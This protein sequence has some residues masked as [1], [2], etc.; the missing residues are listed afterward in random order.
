MTVKDEQTNQPRVV[1]AADQVELTGADLIA[2]GQ[3]GQ[4]GKWVDRAADIL[5]PVIA[6]VVLCTIW[7]LLSRADPGWFPRAILP[8]PSE[9]AP[10]LVETLGSSLM[11]E[12]LAVTLEEVVIAFGI[13]LVGGFLLG[14]AIA[15]SRTFNR[16]VYP[17]VIAF[18]S[19]P[20]SAFAP[21]FIAWFGF[22]I[23]SKIALAVTISFF[24]VLATTITGLNLYKENEMLL[25]RS[26]RATRIQTFFRLR[27]PNA[28]PTIF[29]GVK[30]S[31]TFAVVGVVFGEM[32]GANEGIGL[33]IRS[34]AA[35]LRM[36][37]MFSYLVILAVIGVLIVLLAEIA[38]RKITFWNR[39]EGAE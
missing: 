29:A 9:I 28:M 2:A 25:M 16:A 24:P 6:F 32:I 34:S 19:V 26:L 1:P 15:L 39:A 38:E 5:L 12:N 8:P 33:L 4:R 14:V 3:A 37:L 27:L 30:T 23:S 7:E 22:G 36:D 31:L 35:Q 17:L 13:C 11:W 10:A 21:L 18:Q 20:R